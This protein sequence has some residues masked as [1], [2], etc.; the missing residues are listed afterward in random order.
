MHPEFC[1]ETIRH[2]GLFVN[3]LPGYGHTPTY[4]EVV[5]R[6]VFFPLPSLGPGN[7]AH[8]RRTNYVL[9]E[10]CGVTHAEEVRTASL[11]PHQVGQRI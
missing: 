11:F 3:P 10:L 2:V 7:V 1:V 8:P 4:G 5:T 9:A 6:F